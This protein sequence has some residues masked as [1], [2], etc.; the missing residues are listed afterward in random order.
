MN[1]VNRI[2][3]PDDP[4]MDELC[5]ELAELASSLEADD[6]W[7]AHQLRQCGRYGVFEWFIP[8]ELGGQGWSDEDVT[9]GYLRLSAACLTTTFII[10]QR[11]GACRR[12]AQSPREWAQRECLPA[13]VQ[14]GHFATVAIS[15]LT[16]SRQHL[17][18][19][20]LTARVT[21]TSVVLDGY[22]PWVTGAAFADWI[23]T[24]ATLEDGS[25]VLMAVPGKLPGVTVEP[26]LKLVGVSGSQTGSVRF[27]QAEVPRPWILAGPASD[28]M[29][30]G[31]GA[32]AGG[33]QTSTLATGLSDAA[34]R[35]LEREAQQRGELA[36]PAA[37]LREQWNG[38]RDDLLSVARGDGACSLESLRTRAN[39]LVL[40]ATQSALAAAKGN[41]FVVGHPAG[42]WCRE[43]LFFL[44]WSCPQTVLEAGMCELAG[45]GG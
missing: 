42:R 15:H 25:Q 8:P 28:V 6:A 7:P 23:V 39:S 24:G 11:T 44:V 40:R 36:Q 21:D 13:L 27:Q 31:V 35:F 12:I 2:Q 20:V 10:T 14:G 26:A 19:P 4:A 32:R 30:T 9:R 5:D 43:A 3:H 29:K 18:E 22:S 33:L 1:H 16:T 45:L 17:T 34:V 41:G 37:A 38:L